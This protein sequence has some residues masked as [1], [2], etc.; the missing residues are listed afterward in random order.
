[1]PL[2]RNE[3][4]ITFTHNF[5]WSLENHEIRFG[6]DLVHHMMD[7]WQPEIGGGPRGVFQFPGTQPDQDSGPQLPT[8]RIPWRHS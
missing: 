3:D 2:D 4:S 1:M 6:Y 7:H 5:S 8:S